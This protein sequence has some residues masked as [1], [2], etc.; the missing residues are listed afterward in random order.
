L[1]NRSLG[2]LSLDIVAK[3]GGFVDGL[4][5]AERETTKRAKAIE[6]ALS[7][8]VGVLAGAASI[9]TFTAYIKNATDGLDKLNDVADV[10]GSTV[11]KISA[12][13]DIGARVGTG[14]DT[15]EGALVKLNAQISA[16]DGKNEVSRALKQIGLDAE[17]LKRLDPAEALRQTSVALAKITDEGDRARSVQL[18]FGKSVREVAPFLKDLAEAGQLNATVTAKQAQEA[19]KFN[20]QIFALQKE[21]TDIARITALPVIEQLNDFFDG[22]SRKRQAYGSLFAGLMDN[23]R[24]DQADDVG[25]NLTKTFNEIEAAQK[26]IA[27]INQIS[28]RD[29]LSDVLVKRYETESRELLEQIK[30]LKQR[31][32]YLLLNGADPG[33]NDPAELARRGRAPKDSPKVGGRSPLPGIEGIPLDRTEAF[34][35]FELAA[36]AATNQALATAQLNDAEKL[37]I[38]GLDEMLKAQSDLNALLDAT[39][40]AQLAKAREQLDLL[41]EALAKTSDPA[42]I[43]KIKEAMDAVAQTAN[44]LPTISEESKKAFDEMGEFAKEAARGIQQSLGDGVLQAMEGNFK[45]IGDSFK[46]TLD[47][48]AA[49]IVAAQLAKKLFGDFDKTGEIGGILGDLAN[50]FKGSTGGTGNSGG[51]G[52]FETAFSAVASYFAGGFAEGGRIPPGHFGIVGEKGPEFAFGGASGLNIT[53]NGAGRSMVVNNHFT[54]NGPTSRETQGQIAAK[55]AD[56]LRRAEARHR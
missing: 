37:R 14:I 51:G 28:S 40:S 23:F 6:T 46:R 35:E 24:F 9:S 18:L 4:S 34:R 41:N 33:S 12:L 50:M 52:F 29:G 43:M 17:E 16:A 5:K 1:A 44:L 56:A 15:I 49:D 19:E 54:I 10:T 13:E 25:G 53:P 26:R 42:Q 27:R 45:G 22:I 32:K 48:M 30:L 11:E 36:Q 20:K 2:V 47:R 3:I 55:A 38:A 31:E 39:P 21:L 7:G 8:A